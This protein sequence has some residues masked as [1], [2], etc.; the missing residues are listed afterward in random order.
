MSGYWQVEV[1]ETDKQKT[2]FSTPQVLFEFNV[3]P[4]GLTNAPATFQQF[5]ECVLAGLTPMQCLVYLDDIIIFSS[6]FL[7]R[8]S[9]VLTKLE[10]AGLRLHLSKCQFARKQVW[11][12][13]FHQR[14]CQLILTQSRLYRT[15]QLQ[16]HSRN[17]DSSLDL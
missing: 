16:Q 9:A 1:E 15:T 8:L 5:M 3:V 14:V 10:E 12:I 17:C 7:E 6:S 11:V 13:L 4:F 2:A